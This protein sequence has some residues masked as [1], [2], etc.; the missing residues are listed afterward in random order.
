[1]NVKGKNV[2]DNTYLFW[3]AGL[4]STYRLLHLLF[5]ENKRVQP[6]YLNFDIDHIQ[7]KTR[8]RSIETNRLNLLWLHIYKKL[9]GNSDRLLPIKYIKPF[10]LS[11]EIAEV[12]YHLYERDGIRRSKTQFSY[13]LEWAYRNK[14]Y[15]ENSTLAT[16]KLANELDWLTQSYSKYVYLTFPLKHFGKCELLVLASHPSRNWQTILSKTVSCWYHDKPVNECVQ[17]KNRL[18]YITMSEKY[19]SV[20]SELNKRV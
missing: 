9:G 6:L 10:Q 1:M 2:S 14:I 20:I 18:A 5:L 3:T 19:R 17:C 16:D 11:P 13:C 15:I 8:Q 4:D 12:S 7:N